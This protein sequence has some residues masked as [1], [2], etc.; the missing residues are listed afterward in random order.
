MKRQEGAYDRNTKLF[1]PY[2]Q[3][4][5]ATT[6]KKTAATSQSC[7]RITTRFVLRTQHFRQRN[8]FLWVSC[9]TWYGRPMRT[10]VY[11][12]VR[13]EHITNAPVSPYLP[14]VEQQED[15]FQNLRSTAK[16]DDRQDTAGG[17]WGVTKNASSTMHS[18]HR[19][20][21][22]IAGR[23]LDNMFVYGS[24]RGNT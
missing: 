19:E 12:E 18:L 17:G 24:D 13:S 5:V 14:V 7:Y 10:R 6:N 8:A 22:K 3:K 23:A 21:S 16:S 2:N 20:Y 15:R 1:R 9:A 4:N 11:S